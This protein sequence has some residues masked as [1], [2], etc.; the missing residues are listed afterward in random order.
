MKKKAEERKKNK[1]VERG[2]K[3]GRIVEEG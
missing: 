1:K 2:M 3:H